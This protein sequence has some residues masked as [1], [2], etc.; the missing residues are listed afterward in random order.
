MVRA[1][2]LQSTDCC[3]H[4]ARGNHGWRMHRKVEFCE[5]IKIH[6]H[7][8]LY[9]SNN[10]QFMNINLL[11]IKDGLAVYLWCL[12]AKTLRTARHKRGCYESIMLANEGDFS[13]VMPHS[14]K[15]RN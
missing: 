8:D 2:E 7:Y 13:L 5:G 14:T 1:V 11:L 10:F 4:T 12:R 9:R 3:S 15:T 6:E